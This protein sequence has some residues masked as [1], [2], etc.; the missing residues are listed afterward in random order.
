VL[1]PELGQLKKLKITILIQ[2][3]TDVFAIILIC[4][5]RPVLLS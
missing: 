2:L 4:G 3:L 5:I 1:L